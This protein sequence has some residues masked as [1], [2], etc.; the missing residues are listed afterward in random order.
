MNNRPTLLSETT[1]DVERSP[2][3]RQAAVV[4]A[5]LAIGILLMGIQLWIL[6]VALEL[7]LAGGTPDIWLLAVI[8]GIVFLG[9]LLMLYIL[10]QR[11]FPQ[12]TGGD[13]TPPLPFLGRNSQ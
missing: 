9:G 11:R 5:A 3:P 12:K 2:A 10:H 7:Y 13:P 4:L 1:G 6:T 8:S